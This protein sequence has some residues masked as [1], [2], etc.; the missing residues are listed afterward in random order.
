VALIGEDLRDD[1]E[2]LAFIGD[3]KRRIEIISQRGPHGPTVKLLM[4]F[5]DER[6]DLRAVANGVLSFDRT[7]FRE[8]LDSLR[9]A[10]QAMGWDTPRQRSPQ[11]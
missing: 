6:G 11:K 4:R 10:A 5:R 3:A 1:E 8:L 2:R 9:D 7:M